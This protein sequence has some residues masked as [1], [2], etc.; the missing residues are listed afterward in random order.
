MVA[1][2]QPRQPGCTSLRRRSHYGSCRRRTIQQRR[3]RCSL[4]QRHQVSVRQSINQSFI[5]PIKTTKTKVIWQ[6]AES[7][8][9]VHPTP[10]LCSPDGSIGLTLWPPFAIAYFGW[11]FEGSTPNLSFLGG[12]GTHL[13]QCVIGP[14]KCTCQI[15]S[16]PCSKKVVH[17]P[18][19]DNLVTRC[20]LRGKHRV[21][22]T[23]K[24]ASK[25]PV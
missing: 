12:Q 19:I 18:H 6:K 15:T 5:T 24:L 7:L 23:G 8:W 1:H 21:I 20:I 14:N 16:T 22:C 11:R 3:W 17:Q 10:R 4:S 2:A 25:P 13:T 9:Q